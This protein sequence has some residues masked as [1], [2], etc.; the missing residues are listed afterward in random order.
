MFKPSFDTLHAVKAKYNHLVFQRTQLYGNLWFNGESPIT[1]RK[2]QA[3]PQIPWQGLLIDDSRGTRNKMNK[4][5][6]LNKLKKK[7]YGLF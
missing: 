1:K 6:I 5:N 2:K 7:I 3:L 4:K